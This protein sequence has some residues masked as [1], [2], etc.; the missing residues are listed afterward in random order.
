[1]ASSFKVKLVHFLG[2]L[3]FIIS[4][5]V[6]IA[7]IIANTGEKFEFGIIGFFAVLVAFGFFLTRYKKGK[8]AENNDVSKPP[9][10]TLTEKL[11]KQKEKSFQKQ[12]SGD[13]MALGVIFSGENV[14]LKKPPEKET[15]PL[16][17]KPN[18]TNEILSN[19]KDINERIK[20]LEQIISQFQESYYNGDIEVSESEFESFWNELK[21]IDP[22]NPLLKKIET[23][24]AKKTEKQAIQETEKNIYHIEYVD[25]S[26]K[27]S[28]RD[29]EI[30]GFLEENGKLYINAFCHKAN[31]MR[32]FMVDRVQSISI[33]GGDP[34]DNPQQFLWNKY[35]NSDIYKTQIAL[36][37]HADEI[38]AL[39]FLAKADGKMLK[40]EREI[41]GRYIDIIAPGIDAESVEKMLKNTT[42]EL[43]QFNGILKRAKSWE[44]DAKKLVMDAASQIKA[45]KKQLDPME[46]AT[47]EKLKAVIG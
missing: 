42:C 41:I 6:V 33:Q 30:N 11:Q 4:L 34:I 43:S 9:K 38:L 8:K 29:I 2:W 46:K 28:S 18:A 36:N 26:G 13:E 44:L 10:K 21:A 5:C 39:I 1:M 20:T 22:N 15:P 3:L 27:E 25:S 23:K 35:Q 40:N 12:V 14:T 17:E 24:T 31:A 37:D 19:I 32:Q 7:G 47:F 45:L 16:A